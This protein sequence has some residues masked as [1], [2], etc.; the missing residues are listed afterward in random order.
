MFTRVVVGRVLEVQRMKKR[1][2]MRNHKTCVYIIAGAQS[3]NVICLC[4]Y[5]IA[6]SSSFTIRLNHVENCISFILHFKRNYLISCIL[7]VV[8][9]VL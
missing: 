9:D 6:S 7:G 4:N 8:G 3:E 1:K 2:R 5:T